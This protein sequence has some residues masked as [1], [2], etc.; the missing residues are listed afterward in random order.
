MAVYSRCE[1]HGPFAGEVVRTMRKQIYSLYGAEF[2]SDPFPTYAEMRKRSPVC[3]HPGISGDNML[4]F[5]TGA[6]E[7]EIVLRDHKRFVKNWRN[8]RTREELAQLEPPS[9]L[10]LLLDQHMLN[11]D[12]SD[13]TRLRGLVNKAFTPR[14]VNR[15]QGR[16][17][18]IADGLINEFF[19]VGH[20]DLIDAYAF[21]LPIVV[22]MEMLGIPVQDRRQFRIW[23]HAFIAP[24]LTED[25]WQEARK[26]LVEFTDFLRSIFNERRRKPQDDLISALLEAEEAEDKLSEP[27][28]FGMIILLIV[29][30]HETTT[31]LIGNGT[32]ALL[33]HPDQLAL[34]RAK[35]EL[36][37]STVEEV[38][39]YNG[40]A[41][42]ATMRFAA[43]DTVLGGQTIRRGDALTPVLASANRDD[44]R[45]PSPK[46]FDIEREN[47]KHLGFGYGIHYC[48]GAQL[49]R[50]EGTIALNTLFRRL[51]NLRL[52]VP[53]EDI[54]WDT[55]PLIRGMKEMPVRWDT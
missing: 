39:R 25:E 42:R 32:L 9:E 51:P 11:L 29:A 23:S 10:A 26:L 41:E 33:Q 31:N 28:L 19:H 22:I 12:G 43:E 18:E 16:V 8:T 14:T 4:W 6:E 53:P 24:T 38:L 30:G 20:A 47:N 45:F 15:M 27:E 2:K 55:V 35:P 37:H 13:H 50:M 54:E 36:A 5:V 21:P 7:V 34:L 17:Q 3:Y 44:S 1:E 52:D 46:A 40:P 49:A 48:L